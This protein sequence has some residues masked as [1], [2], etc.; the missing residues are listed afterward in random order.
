MKLHVRGIASEL[1]RQLR[2]GAVGDANGQPAVRRTAR[3]MA[4]PCRHCLQLIA[5]GEPML[6]L[7]HR[8]FAEPQPYAEVG[9]IFIHADEC[10]HYDAPTLPPWFAYLTPAL[11]RGYG[12]DHWIKYETGSVVAGPELTTTCQTILADPDVA[13]VHV[14]SKYNCFQCRVDRA[15]PSMHDA[16]SVDTVGR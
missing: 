2:I 13:Y 5:D 9:P 16:H 8:P 15:L 11:V 14:R 1:V 3:G 7:A 10:P 4:N 6:V 12:A